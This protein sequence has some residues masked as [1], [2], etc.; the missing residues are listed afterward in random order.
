MEFFFEEKD[1]LQI[2]TD[3]AE[4]GYYFQPNFLP[5][6]AVNTIRALALQY[7]QNGE[8]HRAGVGK[9]HLHQVNSAVRGDWVHWIDN[10]SEELPELQYF[11]AKI[12]VLIMLVRRYCFLAIKDYETHF[13][14][15]PPNTFYKRHSDRFKLQQHRMLSFVCY[16]NPDWQ[17]NQGG[18]LQLYLPDGSTQRIN[19]QAGNFICF[20]SEIEHEVLM[21]HA[22]RYS[23]TGWMLDQ[24]KELTFL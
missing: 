16:L 10:K 17:E 19:P 9:M 5:E 11:F 6:T 4:K 2:A 18:Q 13:A 23:I 20:R 3:L 24:Y 1:A 22:H 7:F 12:D 15:Y 21:A 14:I 8:M